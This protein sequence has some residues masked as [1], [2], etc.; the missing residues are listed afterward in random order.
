MTGF[1]KTDRIVT[2]AEIQFN[3]QHCCYT[4]LLSRHANYEAIDG[5]V[6]CFHRQSF[7]DP[8]KPRRSTTE[9]MGPLMGTNNAIWGVKLLLT[10]VSSYQADC[11]SFSTLL[12]TQ[13]CCLPTCG[14]YYLPP[15]PPL[16]PTN[17]F[18][19]IAGVVKKPS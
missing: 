7:V 1:A 3:V 11:G 17:F 2:T 18:R 19:Y 8:V 13:H 12:K 5:Q 10:T 15:T 16:P 14:W 9:S 6:C 4:L